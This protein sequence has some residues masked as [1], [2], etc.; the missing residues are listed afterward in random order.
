MKLKTGGKK[1]L[2]AHIET[3][4]VLQQN[5]RYRETVTEEDKVVLVVRL[6][7]QSEDEDV[8]KLYKANY[9]DVIEA[10][11]LTTCFPVLRKSLTE[12]KNVKDINKEEEKQKVLKTLGNLA[13]TISKLEKFCNNT[14][15]N[16]Q[17][18]VKNAKVAVLQR[19]K[20]LREQYFIDMLI[21]IMKYITNEEELKVYHEYEVQMHKA[22]LEKDNN[23]KRQKELIP[24]QKRGH[25]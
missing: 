25:T 8:L 11:F 20:I 19:Q 4:K 24:T 9:S 7:E 12:L 17:L 6:T 18:D 10:N 22:S 3:K 14:L 21:E 2:W 15:I 23:D 1:T 16:T 13:Q 5:S